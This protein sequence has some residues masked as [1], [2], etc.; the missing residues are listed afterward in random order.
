VYRALHDRRLRIYEGSARRS[1]IHVADIARGISMALDKFPSM[2]G[3]VYNLGDESQNHAKL[4]ICRLISQII[5]GVTVEECADAKDLDRRD[6]AVSYAR[7]KALGFQT[8]VSVN[9]GIRE[10]CGPLQ[11]IDDRDSFSNRISD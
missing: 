3:H 10:L 11:W 5:P 9:D 8:A 2:A 1:F 7:I 6:Y 4:D